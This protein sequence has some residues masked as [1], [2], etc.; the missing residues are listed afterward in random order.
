MKVSI[1]VPVYNAEKYLVNCLSYLV[2][3]TLQEIEIIVVDDCSADGSLAILKECKQQYPEKVVL[4]Q[5]E[6]NRGPGGARNLGIQAAKGDYLAFVDNDD[7]VKPEMY[8]LLYKKAVEG[9]Y[10][11][12][13][14]GFFLSG[15]K[16]AFF[17]TP[18][19]LTG[20]LDV[21][22][23]K[24]LMCAKG[25][26]W[27]KIFKTSLFRENKICLLENTP[28][29]DSSILCYIYGYTKSLGLVKEILYLYRERAMS[30]SRGLAFPV[31]VE[32]WI[33]CMKDMKQHFSVMD[34]ELLF[35]DILEYRVYE[36]YCK[37]LNAFMLESKNMDLMCLQDLKKTA[38]GLAKNAWKNPY[39][40][41]KI[42]MEYLKLAQINDD[43]P[44]KL[45][46]MKKRIG[47]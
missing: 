33:E 23:K 47:N 31:L 17:T 15:Q 11:I 5:S 8:E 27:S 25:Y 4:I 32:K 14:C 29:D 39:I 1:I 3:Q 2:N 36:Y 18:E 12:V 40:L 16:K 10:D 34:K 20:I 44:A 43:N 35:Q 24:S 22:K 45:L 41:K 28:F 13:D 21:E 46:L 26:L 19:Q 37:I 42:P 9:N 6:R 38:N 7:Q 30:Y